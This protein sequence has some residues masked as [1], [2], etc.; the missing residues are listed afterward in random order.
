VKYIS[1]FQIHLQLIGAFGDGVVS[2]QY[3]I[4][5]CRELTNNQKDFYDDDDDD[6]PVSP[7]QKGQM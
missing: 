2:M 5:W 3:V 4:K 7:L 6:A 1:P